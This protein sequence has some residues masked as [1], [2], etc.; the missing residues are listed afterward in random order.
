[1]ELGVQAYG[2][3]ISV[4]HSFVDIDREFSTQILLSDLTIGKGN[5]WEHAMI[6]FTA[7][8]IS[9]CAGGKVDNCDF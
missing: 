2:L 6:V 3:Y 5:T 1:L 8:L 4:T 7:F 9:S